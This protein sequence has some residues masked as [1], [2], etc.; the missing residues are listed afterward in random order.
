[1][2]EER[3]YSRYQKNVIRRYYENRESLSVQR[4]GE[5]VSELYLTA[6]G[7]KADRLW[8][9]AEKMLSTVEANE[10]WLAKTVEDR[11]VE[12]L[13]EMVKTLF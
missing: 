13:A 7:K 10:K 12:Q 1:M 9:Q 6:P 4:L 11:N 2:A 3:S 8:A 5:I